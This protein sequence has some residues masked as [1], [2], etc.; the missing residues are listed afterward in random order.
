MET[1][2]N[3]VETLD[4]ISRAVEGQ[5]SPYFFI[6]DISNETI[7]F[8]LDGLEEDLKDKSFKAKFNLYL[9]LKRFFSDDNKETYFEYDKDD[10]S[11]KIFH[12]MY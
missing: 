6:R 2:R 12:K 10:I 7:E 4:Q 5:I 3:Y 11:V 8:I 1:Y 9:E